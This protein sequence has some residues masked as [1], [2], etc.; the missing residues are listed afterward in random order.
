MRKAYVNGIDLA[1]EVT[2]HGPPLI[3]IMGYRLNSRAWPLD[4]VKGLANR[5]QV[6]L[7]DNRG[8]GLS[9]KP[10]DGYALSNM[11]EDVC[12]LMDHLDIARANVLG[13]SM[14]GAIAQELVCNHPER[15]GSLV[16]CATLCGGPTAVYATPAV[17]RIMRD[18]DGL[19][20]ETIARRIWTV[21]YE[22]GYLAK[23]ADKAEAQMRR[24]LEQPTP[25]HAAD[26]Q[27]QAFADFDASARLGSIRVPTMILT[28]D[29]DILIRPDN[30]KILAR[31]IPGASLNIIRGCAHRVFWEATDEC[32]T[33]IRIF[34]ERSESH[35]DVDGR[36][37]G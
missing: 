20:P 27:F 2:G 16:L 23:N 30:S 28:G 31:L 5:F 22:P 9:G 4:F 24:E 8:T 33:R 26:L 15:V 1:F 21:T 10:T 13:Y 35:F 14:G 18:L 12:G 34:L 7:F 32:V 11:A 17:T 29:R 37:P 6:I 25:L 19:D 3:L 36:H